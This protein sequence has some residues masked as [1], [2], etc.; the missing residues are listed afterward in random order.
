MTDNLPQVHM[1]RCSRSHAIFQDPTTARTALGSR[2]RL[3][4]LEPGRACGRDARGGTGSGDVG[5]GGSRGVL[6]PGPGG[7]P[8]A[9]QATPIS[10]AV[11]VRKM[12]NVSARPRRFKLGA[13]IGLVLAVS[14]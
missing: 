13:L 4:A 14:A 9:E 3:E 5:C 6:R 7:S 1:S 2:G 11:F 10:G 8:R 12:R